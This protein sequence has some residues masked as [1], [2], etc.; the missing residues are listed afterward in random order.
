MVGTRTKLEQ[1]VSNMEKMI[2]SDKLDAIIRYIMEK[3]PRCKMMTNDTLMAYDKDGDAMGSLLFIPLGPP[4][5][6]VII[7]G[8]GL[9]KLIGWQNFNSQMKLLEQP[10]STLD[11]RDVTPVQKVL[12]KKVYTRDIPGTV[13]LR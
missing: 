4:M 12:P 8:G 3:A 7:M 13:S 10:K 11:I 6:K 5:V 1:G 9:L 2:T